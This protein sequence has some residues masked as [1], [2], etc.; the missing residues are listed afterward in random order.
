MKTCSLVLEKNEHELYLQRRIPGRQM[1][2]QEHGSAQLLSG[3]RLLWPE[4]G[5]GMQEK[6]GTPHFD[7]CR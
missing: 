3:M 6:L 1:S 7:C 4:P 2:T 5:T